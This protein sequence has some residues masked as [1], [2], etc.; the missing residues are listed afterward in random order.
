MGGK[1]VLVGGVLAWL[2]MLVIT[3]LSSSLTPNLYLETPGM[4][5]LT[6][7]VWLVGTVLLYLMTGLIYSLAYTVMGKPLKGSPFAKG[8]L[9][10]SLIWF[11]GSLPGLM[12]THLSMNV[13]AAVIISWLF[14]GL[15]N[16]LVA[17]VMIAF[18]F[19]A[20]DGGEK[21]ERPAGGKKRGK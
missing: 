20:L 19:D 14:T 18:V 21:A 8:L 16:A 7:E 17:G 5:K 13:P 9:Y 4:W 3:L 1:S 15:L 10:G 2:A 12:M 6:G 11:I